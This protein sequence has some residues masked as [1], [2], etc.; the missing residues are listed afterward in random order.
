MEMNKC[1]V[2]LHFLYPD[3]WAILRASL[4]YCVGYLERCDSMTQVLQPIC[5]IK[6]DKY[7]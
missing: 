6:G 1:I 4:I 7:C 5:Y 3:G 2:V